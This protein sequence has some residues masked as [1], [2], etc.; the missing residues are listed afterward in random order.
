[1]LIGQNDEFREVYDYYRTREEN[2]LKKMQALMAVACKLL[3][4]LYA[5]VTKGTRYDPE[6]HLSDI[7][8]PQ[9]KAA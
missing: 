6:K 8:R 5:M 2:P 7:R 3:R 9:K 4:V 1:M